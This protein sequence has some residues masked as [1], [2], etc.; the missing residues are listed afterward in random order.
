M[1]AGGAGPTSPT[2]PPPYTSLPSL[3]IAST[4]VSFFSTNLS[5]TSSFQV[6]LFF[7]SVV[8]FRYARCLDL[9]HKPSPLKNFNY[10]N[11]GSACEKLCFKL[12]DKPA[13]L[14]TRALCLR[15]SFSEILIQR[16][17]LRHNRF[18]LSNSFGF[19]VLCTP[20]RFNCVN[21]KVNAV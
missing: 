16:N 6:E 12:E 5:F 18:S 8:S 17:F 21:I 20:Q 14:E 4:L 10:I 15:E 2:T 7:G 19:I 13:V 3:T 1:R 9:S 11:V